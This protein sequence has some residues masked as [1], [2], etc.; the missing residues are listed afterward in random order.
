VCRPGGQHLLFTVN[1]IAGVKRR[2]FESVAVG[3]SVGRAGFNTVTAENTAVVIDVI[4]LGVTLGTAHA[5]FG[6]ILGGFDVN[7][8]R[9][10]RRRT[11]KARHALLQAI[12]VALEHMDTP[13]ALL[14]LSAA[15]GSRAVRVV[16]HDGRLKNLPESNGH[17]LGD[18]GD[19]FYHWHA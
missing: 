14:K 4:D 9:R 2:N 18:G 1:Q 16:L 3:D 7:T 17:A 19:I 10:A 8:I 11:E 5:V 13:I 12:F 6:S 15:K